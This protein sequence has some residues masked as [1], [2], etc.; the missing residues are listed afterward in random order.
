MIVH[1][2]LANEIDHDDIED[3]MDDFMEEHFNVI[4]DEQ[5]HREMAEALL[6]VRQQL[7]FSAKNEYDLPSGSDELNKL[8]AFN[9]KNMTNVGEM[10]KYMK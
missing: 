7:T 4:S 2:L 3:C 8:R 6:K 9:A 10:S 1:L 5:S